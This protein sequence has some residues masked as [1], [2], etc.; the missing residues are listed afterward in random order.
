LRKEAEAAKLE[1][2]VW[3]RSSSSTCCWT[4]YS[5]TLGRPGFR[6]HWWKSLQEGPNQ[7]N[8]KYKGPKRCQLPATPPGGPPGRQPPF[9][10]QDN[11][12][13]PGW[14]ATQ[15]PPGGHQEVTTS[16]APQQAAQAPHGTNGPMKG[17]TT[18][19][20]DERSTFQLWWMI[21]NGA[22]VMG[23]TISANRSCL[24]FIRGPK[25]TTGSK[26]RSINFDAQ[27]WET[28]PWNPTYPSSY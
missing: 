10:P 26:R 8:N 15:G 27:Y 13:T 17:Q 18:S 22:E 3:T 5:W 4:N 1:A 28:Q 21:N 7:S 23:T 14:T 16:T 11:Q 24:S 12:R 25:V 9:G 6:P 2:L 19:I 20:F